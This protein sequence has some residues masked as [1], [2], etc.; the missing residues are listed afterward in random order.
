M[1]SGSGWLN[2]SIFPSLCTLI[3]I[4][5]WKLPQSDFRGVDRVSCFILKRAVLRLCNLYL[6]V[7]IAPSSCKVLQAT[8]VH[9]FPPPI[10]VMQCPTLGIHQHLQYAPHHPLYLYLLK[11]HPSL[12]IHH[13]WTCQTVCT[14]VI[15]LSHQLRHFKFLD[16][17]KSSRRQREWQR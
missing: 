14:L 13:A 15:Q 8:M 16:C 5:S 12:T 17:M 6:F 9:C 7:H 4:S 11:A 2:V 3:P 10:E 1:G